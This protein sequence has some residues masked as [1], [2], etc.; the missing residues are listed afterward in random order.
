MHKSPLSEKY[1]NLIFIMKNVSTLL[2]ITSLALNC[3][4]QTTQGDKNQAEAKLLKTKAPEEVINALFKEEGLYKD[5]KP[6]DEVVELRS[7][8]SKYFRNTDGTISAIIG[9]GDLHY[10]ESGEWKEILSYI[11][12]N[13]SN[14]Y[15]Q[16]KFASVYNWHKVFFPEKP[17]MQIVTKIKNNV[18]QDWGQPAMVWLD[19]NANVIAEYQTNTEAIGTPVKDSIKY[20]NIFPHTDAVIL[21]SVT[22]KKLSYY[23]K[24]S[25]ILADKPEG[26]VYLAFRE[27]INTNPS[28]KLSG[29]KS[30]EKIFASLESGQLLQNILFTDESGQQAVEIETP[31]YFQKDKALAAGEPWNPDP[32]RFYYGSYLVKESNSDYETYT[33]VPVQWLADTARLFPV[34]ID[35]VTNYYPGYTW[36]TYTVYRSDNTGGWVC[37]P[38]TY[39]GRTYQYDISYGWIDDTFPTNNPFLYGYSTFDITALQDNACINSVQYNWYHYGSRGCGTDVTLKFGRVTG[40]Y[41][42]AIEPS[43]TITGDAIL[44]NNSYFNGTSKNG[45]GW[46]NYTGG[47]ADFVAALPGNQITTGWAYNCE[48]GDCNGDCC[49]FLCSGND[50][51]YHHVY[52]YESSANKPYVQVNYNLASTAATSATTSASPT[53]PGQTVTLSAVGGSLGTGANWQWYSG[54]C[55]G[56]FVGTGASISV[57]PASTTTYYVRAEGTCNTTGCVSVTLSVTNTLSVA[58]TGITGTTTICNGNSTTLTLS[59]GSA[60]T[61]ATAEWFTG[62]CG[63]PSAGTGNSITV[64]PTAN[65][66]YYVRYNGTCNITSCASVTVTVN[67][68]SVAPTGA[69]GTTTICNGNSTTLTVAGGSPG[70]GAVAQ[71]F[72]GSCGGTSAGTGNSITVSPTSTTSYY[73]R[74]SGTCNTTSC[75]T[76]TLNVNTLSVA[77]TGATG[78]TTICNGNSTTLTVA[79]GTAGTGAVA[80]WFTGSCGGTSAGTGNSITVSP[81]TTTTYYVRYNGTCN[82]TTCGTVTVTVNTLSVAPTGITGTTTICNGNSTS[83]TVSGGNPGTAAVAEWFTGSCGGTSVGTGNSITV[84]PTSTTTYYV[85]YSGTCNTTTCAS[86]TVTVNQPSVAATSIS[87]VATICTGSSTTLSVVGGALGTG[88]SWQW[89]TGS[90]NGTSAGTGTSITVS[91]VS[92]TTYY[93]NA[94]GTCNTTVCQSLAVNVSVL[95]NGNISGTTAICI[96]QSATLTFNFTSGTGPFNVV[97]TDGTTN[98]PLTGINS[99]QTVSVTPGSTTTYSFVSITDA[100]TCLRNSGFGASATITVNPLPVVT[101]SALGPYCV[102]GTALSLAPFGSP[103][104]GLFSG[105][106][107]TGPQGSQ[108]FVPSSAGVGTHALTY[109]YTNGNNCTSS[110]TRNVTVN[111]LPVVTFT[112]PGGPYCANQSTPVSLSGTPSGGTFSGT[113]VTGNTFIPSNAAVGNNVITYTYTDGNSCTNTAQQTI[114]IN[115]LPLVTFSGFAGPYCVSQ[116]SPVLLTGNHTSGTFSGTG[117]TN[118]GSG[119]A[120]FTPSTA[121]AGVFNITYTYTDGNGCTNTQTQSVQVVALPLV[122][123][124]GLASSYCVSN[125]SV[126]L[127]G[128]PSGG[129]FSGTPAVTSG[130]LFSPSTGVGNYTITYTYINGNGC[131][132]STSVSTVVNALPVVSFS[133]FNVP[134]Q[135]CQNA[136]VVNLTGT[137]SGGTFSGQGVTSGGVFTPSTAGLGTFTITYSYSDGNGCSNTSTQSVTVVA[138]PTVSFTGLV[139]DYCV[140]DAIVI[141]TGNQSGGTF[142]GPGITNTGSG[143]AT[144]NP[145][146]AGIGGSYGITYTYIDGNGC[147]ASQTQQTVVHPMPV[148]AFNGLNAAYCIDGASATLT[149]SHAPGGFFT[150]T[151]ISDNGNG[152]AIFDPA[153]AGV[154]GPFAITYSYTDVFGCSSSI[155][156]NTLVNDTPNVS[157]TGLHDICIDQ[158]AL[159]LI[160]IPPGGVFSGNGVSGNAFFPNLAGLGVQTVSYYYSDGNGCDA[161]YSDSARVYD[162]P[163]IT[164]QPNDVQVCPGDAASFGV[165]AFGLGLSYQWYVN[166]GNGFV[167]LNNGGVYS[168][169]T[170]NTLSI[171]AVPSTIDGY[172]FHCVVTGAT[173]LTSTTSNTVTIIENP[174]PTINTQ[175]VDFA[176]CAGD[177]AVFSVSASGTSLTYQWQ[178]N[179]GGGWVNVTN[180]AGYSGATTN[181]LN[182]TGFNVGMDGY[183]YQCVVT[184]T[185]NCTSN[186]TSNPA[187]LNVTTSPNIATQPVTQNICEGDNAVFT[188]AAQGSGLSYQWQENTGSGFV[189]VTNGGA[190]SGATTATLTVA[191]VTNGMDGYQYQCI[192]SG[193]FCANTSVSDVVLINITTSPYIAQQPVDAYVCPTDPASFSVSVQGS[194]I[195]YQWQVNNGSGWINVNLSGIYSGVTSSTLSIASVFANMDGYQYRCIVNGAFCSGTSVS[196]V[197]TIIMNGT[198]V[199]A[200]QPTDMNY[201]VGDNAAFSVTANGTGL[202]YQWQVNSGSGWSDLVNGINYSG[203]NNSTLNILTAPLSFDGN[204]Y[205]VIVS[206]SINCSGSTTSNAVLFNEDPNPFISSQPVDQYVC[207]GDN[208]VFSVTASGSG[209]TYQWQVNTGGG[210]VNVTTGGVYSGATS[211]TLNITGATSGMDGYTYQ[212]IINGSICT[213]TSITNTVTL[214]G[215]TSPYISVQPQ[216]Q[217]VCIGDNVIMSV[218]ANGSG[219]TYQWQVN[220]GSGFVNVTN[221]G[222]Y[223][224]ANAASL[225]IAGA[226]LGMNNYQYQ[227]IIN[228]VS[229][230]DASTS[231][232]VTLYVG[233]SPMIITD[234]NNTAICDGFDASFSVTTLGNNLTYQWQVNTGSGFADISNGGVYSNA[235]TT[236]L[237]ITGADVSMNGY[238]YQ[239]IVT[240][241]INCALTS[242]SASAVLT[243]NPLPVVSISGLLTQYCVNAPNVTLTGIPSGGTFSGT[244]VTGTTFSP[245]TAGV[246]GPYPVLYEY[247]DGNGCYNSATIN[248]TVVA[249][250]VVS[251]SGLAGPYCINDNTPVALTGSPSGGTFSGTGITGNTFVPSIAQLGNNSVTYTYTNL[252][253]CVNSQTQ[254]AVV[255]NIPVVSFSGLSAAY[256]EDYSTP[257]ILTGNNAGGTFTSNG[258]GLTDNGNGTASYVASVAGAGT[259]TITYTY[260]NGN[261]CANSQ[262]QS[263]LV[264]TLPVLTFS[265]LSNQYC[266]VDPLA[267]L[268]GF[269]AGGTFSGPGISGNTFNPATAGLGLHTIIY[270]YT[271]GSTGCSN[272]VAQNTIVRDQPVA[273]AGVGGNVCGLT[274]SLAAAPSV[275]TGT[276]TVTGP[277]TATY[278]PNANAANATVT[279]SGYGTYSFTW[280]ENNSGCSDAASVTV[281]F[282]N[283]PVVDAGQGGSECDLDFT[284]T[285]STSLGT[286]TWSASGPGTAFYT[287]I[288]NPTASVMVSTS[289]IY[290]F[291]YA[292]T[293][294]T[295]SASDQ[296]TVNFNVLPVANAGQDGSECDLNFVLNA[297]P[298][299]GTGTWTQLSGP[300]TSAFAP[301]ANDPSATVTVSS[302]GTYT[303][304]WT[305]D[306]NGCTSSDN[307]T[308][309]YHALPVVSISGLNAAYCVNET[310]VINIAGTPAGG[311]FS[312]PGMLGTLFSPSTAGVGV[313]TIVYTYT[314]NFGCTNSQSQSVEVY[315]ISTTSFTGLAAEYCIDNTAP[316]ALTGTP[317]GGTYTGSGI[318]GSFFTPSVAGLGT[319]TITYS[320]ANGNGCLNSGTQTVTVNA[321]PVVSFTGL[322]ADYCEDAAPATLIG[323]PAGG[324][325]TVDGNTVTNFD[326]SVAGEGTHT[327]TYTYTDGN[328][329][330]NSSSQTVIVHALP[331]VITTPSG[332]AAFCQGGSVLLAASN[333]FTSYTWSNG[334][335]N[336]SF[337]AN[338]TGQYTVDVVDLYGCT[339]TSVPV[340]VTV[341]A[342][343]VVDLG[344]DTTICT[345]N[346]VTLDAGN[347]VSYVWSP[348]GATTQTIVA[349]NNGA[350]MVTVTDAN[351]CVGSDQASVTVA[352]LLQP[353]VTSSSNTNTF[354]QGGSLTLDAGP[355]YSSYAWSDGIT[356]SQTMTVTQA[357]FF[358]VFVTDNSGC[359]GASTPVSV[360]MFTVPAP[361][362]FAD[363]PLEFCPGE[364]VTLSAGIGYTSYA[365]SPGGETTSSIIV[366]QTGSYVLSVQ[367]Q[368]SCPGTSDT[369]DVT[370][371]DV[372]TPVIQASGPLQFCDGDS[373]I[374]SV[375]GSYASYL[376]TSGS[377]T[378]EILVTENGQYG[379]TVM[380][381][382]GCIDSSQTVNP[383]TVN[384]WSPL[385]FILESGDSLTCT[386]AFAGY[387]WYLNGNLLPG[388]DAQVYI[389][390]ESGNYSVVVTDDHGCEGGSNIIEHSMVGIQDVAID[391]NISIYPNP[392]RGVFTFS[393]LFSGYENLRLELTNALGQL[394]IPVEDVKDVMTVKRDYNLNHLPDG[395]YMLTVRTDKGSVTKR[396][397]KN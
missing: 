142:S 212:C 338:Q 290:T 262:T 217:S 160:G 135:Y 392:T 352:S 241:S 300:G 149:G 331:L 80:E 101:F 244:G 10:N 230:P 166:D 155:S 55:G 364:S 169:A 167:V 157:F 267:T 130:G 86:T 355:G 213:G 59:G 76:V 380:D 25:S 293:N 391:A 343:P 301:N 69:T 345:G 154:G 103:A 152:T 265:G 27:T 363:G 253:G 45:N 121:G 274:F 222:V 208:A 6:E 123:I 263:I 286:G 204:Q 285:G 382:N 172:Q 370:V 134:H 341:N 315:D 46:Q 312:G 132:N 214:H 85:R 282:Y 133:G 14:E 298:T 112:N 320:A 7:A 43:C 240:G 21:N 333:G 82:T 348:N 216:D 62:S 226:T 334:N 379:V 50:G 276:W 221:G 11:F 190:Y 210:F 64:A 186:T 396:I 249:Q 120:N 395:M 231:N 117:I 88:A 268:T 369:I 278:S 185:I 19:A 83:L 97:Y 176:A 94:V 389:A 310:A 219:L 161:T 182:I 48:G 28:W 211:A 164:L 287:D 145:T 264:N 349:A 195:T 224:G 386:P 357:G 192:V 270:Q 49:S 245:A 37:N 205:R 53:C 266:V 239:V 311:T 91:P 129:T 42:L 5:F 13:K 107:V 314:D 137:P 256:C 165:S 351:G 247:T 119:T 22:S 340:N 308:V 60:G 126:Q 2:I 131:S 384:V 181:T 67:T 251:F 203:V 140:N 73:V 102:N 29:T 17:G 361:I 362:V 324:T 281:N 177:N 52:G 150:G 390:Q 79:G 143:T 339:G 33:L 72:T 261:G 15:N 289:G 3:F 207:P 39:S 387:Q 68:L 24:D 163:Q 303:Y 232:A 375:L 199:I 374:L 371:F 40:N 178:V 81:T 317:A 350:Y 93:V 280:T 277:G 114:V 218:T 336:Q 305:E 313:H 365:W 77:P 99:G 215:T 225:I 170:T 325:F 327:V 198:P 297:V 16:Y 235:T 393:A 71:W 100:N 38:G 58:P 65:T 342:L 321:L 238:Q 127:T 283:Q 105:L 233:Q 229:C 250:P 194:G 32:A 187:E 162:I 147:S 23:L 47:V 236:T 296:V 175:P 366:D 12:S 307:V 273:N 156:Q 122:S 223:N 330:V 109:T 66:T 18:Y 158:P 318:S 111:A 258:A 41:N 272:S 183:L 138:V 20:S 75:A 378:P 356:F 368:N 373:V 44:N 228:G 54:S 299:V 353:T 78:T 376:W 346:S 92:T 279:V 31:L 367:D 8:N 271:D 180:G 113:G 259:H 360:T 329:C 188:L 209:L 61:G 197:G 323:T 174:S 108:T 252:N 148:V 220:T 200:Q 227:V 295:C 90:C 358:S 255:N 168:G 206:G 125:A 96:G 9:A 316:V 146:V 189:N 56:T 377:T 328:S 153:A 288:N 306:H 326:P 257:I 70:T 115:G 337:L 309:V 34:V 260:T 292:V 57:S 26:A 359:T 35:P 106:G 234:P 179:T 110:A 191:G 202:T 237:N 269:P 89:Y 294:G 388:A 243:V 51:N 385:G 136:G 144:F 284:F 381:L 242:T 291:T 141:L 196:L 36:P 397:I 171:S 383:V 159:I 63:G 1:S 275:G 335:T 116:T 104:G 344:N 118:L 98:F 128:F 74:Y 95:P 248:V 246:G 319:H 30:N 332:S 84:S 354:C 4:G 347:F 124:S 87:G 302:V 372:T 151:G 394:I 254:V 322:A 184:G 304:T 201:C 139:G 193:S 173:C